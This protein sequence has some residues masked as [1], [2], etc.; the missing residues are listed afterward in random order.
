MAHSSLPLMKQNIFRRTLA[1]VRD[2]WLTVGIT[3]LCLVG[4]EVIARG[5]FFVRDILGVGTVA[6]AIG[7]APGADVYRNQNWAEEY[8][9]EFNETN[10]TRYVEWHSYVYW[11][12]KPYEGK[13]IRINSEGI[14]QTWNTLSTPL[15]GQSKV[16]M[17]GGSALWGTGARDEFTIPSLV[18]KKLNANN[19]NVRVTNFGEGGYVSTQEMIALMV[20]LQKN[21]IPDLVIF[22]DGANDSFSA[23]QQGIAGIPENEFNRAAEFNQFNWRRGL[24]ENLAIYRIPRGISLLFPPSKNLTLSNSELATKA[25]DAYS[26]NIELV[27]SWSREYGFQT[28]Y[29]WQPMIYSKKNLSD[30]EKGQLNRLGERDFFEQVTRALARQTSLQSRKNFFDL[31]NVFDDQSSTVFIDNFHISEEGNELA[32]R[33]ILQILPP[34]TRR[35]AGFT[36]S[37]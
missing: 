13:Y 31:S 14:R 23:F 34:I 30:W 22:Y 17:F 16:F 24:L 2:L 21:N 7:E 35:N 32:S 19:V 27:E 15:S 4:L 25:L 33:M 36:G 11:R 6:Q 28:I 37:K 26:K 5:G 12:R 8:W 10:S 20:E 1:V 3:L 29:L 9:R 18:S